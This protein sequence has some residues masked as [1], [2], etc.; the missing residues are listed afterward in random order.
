MNTSELG[1]LEGLWLARTPLQRQA[2]SDRHF[3]GR[4]SVEAVEQ[5]HALLAFVLGLAKC[6]DGETDP[7]WRLD[8]LAAWLGAGAAPTLRSPDQAAPTLGSETEPSPPLWPVPEPPSPRVESA[9][10]NARSIIQRVVSEVED[11]TLQGGNAPVQPAVL[12]RKLLDKGET[13]R[14]LEIYAALCAETEAAPERRPRIQVIFGLMTEA[15]RR[16]LD[17]RFE[18][19]FDGDPSL[20]DAFSERVR[21]LAGELDRE[22][23]GA[24]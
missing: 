22:G 24:R 19:L 18:G 8:K 5:M 2:L 10:S 15:Q 7:W 6:E 9:P 14:A 17:H 1:L 21:V 11:Q 16:A 23:T 4:A 12:V 3:G 20:R 13:H